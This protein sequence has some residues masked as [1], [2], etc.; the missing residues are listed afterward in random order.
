MF[1]AHKKSKTNDCIDRNDGY[2]F[3]DPW[4]NRRKPMSEAVEQTIA[5][6]Q[7]QIRTAEIELSAK[8][9]MANDLCGMIGRPPIYAD[10]SLVSGMRPVR[11]DE[12]YGQALATAIRMVLARRQH[13]NLG[14]ASVSDIF[15]AL[16]AGGYK[17]GAKTDDYAKRALYSALSKNTTVF[18][19]LPNGDYGLTEWY[20]SVREARAT[21]S[22]NGSVPE[23]QEEAAAKEAAA[24][25]TAPA[26]QEPTEKQ[27]NGGALRMPPLP[28]K[29]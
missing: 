19:K 14:P 29:P 6:I 20:P 18:H 21:K 5:L 22:T 7:E 25:A 10:A 9:R 27:G 23:D 15:D 16:S 26:A 4:L 3:S 13:G 28:P 1:I 17:F 11:S 2:Y 8:K 12:Y 24:E